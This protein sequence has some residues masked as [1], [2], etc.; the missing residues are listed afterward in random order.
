M[1]TCTLQ[2]SEMRTCLC[3]VG[4]RCQCLESW[5]DQYAKFTAVMHQHHVVW[6]PHPLGGALEPD[7]RLK[8]DSQ[9][10]V[11]FLVEHG[12]HFNNNLCGNIHTCWSAP[13]ILTPLTVPPD[14]WTCT[15]IG[16]NVAS[17][18]QIPLVVGL[19]ENSR[20]GKCLARRRPGSA[21]SPR[22]RRPGT[23]T[24]RA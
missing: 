2:F 1:R 22:S 8:A 12:V 19:C 24:R 13:V 18:C 7:M 16:P 9:V 5:V 21:R 20:A 6:C 10:V 14:A 15:A 3:K 11:G 4:T 17:P 23:D